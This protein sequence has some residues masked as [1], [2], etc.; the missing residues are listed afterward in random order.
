[1]KLEALHSAGLF[2][3]GGVMCLDIRGR[4]KPMFSGFEDSVLL[5]FF[6]G[7][8]GELI[9]D[10]SC[11]SAAVIAGDFVFTAGE[12][13]LATQLA[14]R[15]KNNDDR[16][17]MPCHEGWVSALLSADSELETALRFRTCVPKDGFDVSRLEELKNRL[18][19]PFAHC[20]MNG[21]LYR[22]AL[23]NDWS[24][25]FVFNFKNEED[26]LQRAFGQAVT[27]RGRLV[28]AASCYS[29]YSRGVEVEIAADPEFR[30]QGLATAA[31]AAFLLECIRR[32]LIPHW[33]AGNEISLKIAKKLGYEFKESY[34]SLRK[35][36]SGMI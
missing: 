9:T 27:L 19:A 36:G 31:G 30:R 34:V 11:K 22:Q 33:D 10:E 5:S 20:A 21:E 25:A 29:V 3:Y 32:E 26:Y 7:Q 1:M 6:E 15:M 35:K 17:F 4:V 16:I 24:R 14:E 8:S 28:C 12:T 2:C 18:D 23:R 13:T